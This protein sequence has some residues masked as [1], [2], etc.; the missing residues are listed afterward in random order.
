[1]TSTP[2]P[3]ASWGPFTNQKRAGEEGTAEDPPKSPPSLPPPPPWRRFA[4][5]QA[6]VYPPPPLPADQSRRG[7]RF[8]LPCTGP[9]GQLEAKSEELLLAVNAAIRLRRPL[10]VTG[11]PGTGKTSLAYA[12][13]EELK[14][15]RVLTWP[16]TPRSEL[17]DGLYRYEA[18]DRLRDSN[19]A[20]ATTTAADFIKLG[21]VGT[22]FLPFDRPRVLLIDEL[23]KSDI[24]LPNELLNL[25]E[26]GSFSIP[27]LERQAREEQDS[28]VKPPSVATDDPGGNAE[29]PQG[30][31]RC[32]AFPIVVL[33]SNRERDFPAAFHRRCVRVEMHP[34]T[35][36]NGWLEIVSSHFKDEWGDAWNEEAVLEQIKNR[37]EGSE[38]MRDRAIDQLLHA[39]HILGGPEQERPDA[40]KVKQLQ[41][42]LLRPL[43]DSD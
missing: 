24:Q 41:D 43:I 22:A 7:S 2:P 31:V 13:A 20:E 34:P 23:D 11:T 6:Q 40:S 12:I 10:L 36:I 15:G 32:K 1:M 35:K 5:D 17:V 4:D 27:P 16:I 37:L 28:A 9:D 26:E 3:P 25:F 39:M 18:L 42:I 33:T 21:P 8:R 19:R 29:I 30:L 38:N 14:L